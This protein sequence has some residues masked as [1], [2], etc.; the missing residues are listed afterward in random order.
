MYILKFPKFPSNQQSLVNIRDPN[1]PKK[2]TNLLT[3]RFDSPRHNS[4]R[5]HK[6]REDIPVSLARVANV[7]EAMASSRGNGDL[8]WSQW[9]QY[10]KKADKVSKQ[11]RRSARPT[12]PATASLWIG[13]TAKRKPAIACPRLFLP[14][15]T[16]NV[17]NM[18]CIRGQWARTVCFSVIV[19]DK[20]SGR[21]L[22]PSL[23]IRGQ[24]T[25]DSEETNGGSDLI[26][27]SIS[28]YHKCKTAGKNSSF[29]FSESLWWMS[30][31]GLMRSTGQKVTVSNYVSM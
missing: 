9:A 28:A 5:R 24:W 6:A 31:K 3:F 21:V 10:A 2:S 20:K 25:K 27:D 16:C 11:A 18:Q 17:R 7:E 13:C 8:V 23:Y 19:R 4:Q 22:Q 12:M 29:P 14:G 30:W 1:S 26:Q 15:K